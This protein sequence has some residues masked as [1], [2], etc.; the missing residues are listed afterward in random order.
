MFEESLEPPMRILN[1]VEP[2]PLRFAAVHD[3]PSVLSV[4]GDPVDGSAVEVSSVPTIVVDNVDANLNDA[5]DAVVD[6]AYRA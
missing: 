3:P 4:D 6:V 5:V 2:L 1:P